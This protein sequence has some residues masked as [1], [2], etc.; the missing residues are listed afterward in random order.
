VK[1]VRPTKDTNIASTTIVVAFGFTLA[2]VKS[3]T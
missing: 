1:L 2:T 3:F